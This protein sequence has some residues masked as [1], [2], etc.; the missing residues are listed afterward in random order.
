[1]PRELIRPRIDRLFREKITALVQSLSKKFK[2]FAVFILK[3][4]CGNCVLDPATKASSGVYNGN[5]PKPF[6]GRV[7]PVCLG[8]GHSVTEKRQQIKAIVEWSELTKSDENRSLAQGELPYA[9]ALLKTLASA[10]PTLAQA[11]YFLVDGVRCMR[12]TLTQSTGLL[13]KALAHVL[14]KRE[15]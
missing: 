4:P 14:V 8:K 10:E 2:V 13:T 3:T 1:M 6:P 11:D 5:G 7:C 12:A 9:H 15:D